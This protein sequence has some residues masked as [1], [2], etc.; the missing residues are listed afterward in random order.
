MGT[1]AGSTAYRMEWLVLASGAQASIITEAFPM[2]EELP[3][4]T[5]GVTPPNPAPVANGYRGRSIRVLPGQYFDVE[6]GTHYNM[7][8]DYDP[9]I[10]RYIESDPIGMDGGTDTYGYVGGSPLGFSDPLGEAWMIPPILCARYPRSCK[11]I[12]RCVANPQA[13]KDRICKYGSKVYHWFCDVPTCSPTDSP[14]LKGLKL[15]AAETCLELRILVPR[16]CGLKVDARHK[17]EID[18]A[19]RKIKDCQPTC[20]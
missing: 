7:A 4:R 19:Q 16:V 5:A 9:R 1:P 13:C 18:T 14:T 17:R 12:L 10:G 8:R 3:R 20:P 2:I 6:T 11:E 15:G